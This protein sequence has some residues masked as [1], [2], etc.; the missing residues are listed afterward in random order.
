M[1]TL[2]FSGVRLVAIDSVVFRDLC[3]GEPRW[4]GDFERMAA[5]GFEFGMADHFLAEV[6]EQWARGAFT[7]AQYRDA[8]GRAARFISPRLPVLP[9]KADMAALCGYLEAEELKAVDVDATVTW[10]QEAWLLLSEARTYNDLLAGREYTHGGRHLRISLGVGRA[11]AALDEEREQW[12][13]HIK[14]YDVLPPLSVT[15]HEADLLAGMRRSLDEKVNLDPP[16]SVRL[17][18]AVRHM[19]RQI[20]LRNQLDGRYDPQSHKR[21][22]DGID[23]NMAYYLS[24]PAY[25]VTRDEAYCRVA[26]ETASYQAAWIWTPE[27]I[28]QAWK[29]G[30]LP[31]LEWP[32]KGSN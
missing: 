21:R 9:G 30:T 32:A 6:A 2:P 15:E 19:F 26:R 12:T 18:L 8:I 22:N 4:V 7:D 13:G 28:S 25:M 31:P 27:E 1:A 3:Y 10:L 20:R 17:D 29:G 11:E 5:A 16:L 23:F 24:V 14:A